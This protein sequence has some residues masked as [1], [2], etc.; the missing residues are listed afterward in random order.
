M[1]LRLADI[2][3]ISKVSDLVTTTF[4]STMYSNSGDRDVQLFFALK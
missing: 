1:L 2:S 4:E 3:P